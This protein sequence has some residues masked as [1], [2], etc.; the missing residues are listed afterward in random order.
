MDYINSK[1]E[2]SDEFL[3]ET[4]KEVNQNDLDEKIQDNLSSSEPSFYDENSDLPVENIPSV[5][6]KIEFEEVDEKENQT[7]SESVAEKLPSD[8]SEDNQLNQQYREETDK[9][10]KEV[11][12]LRNTKKYVIYVNEENINFIDSLSIEERK[13]IINDIL[14]EQDAYFAA[15]KRQKQRK[16]FLLN[17]L[18]IC[19]TF[20]IGFPIM[21]MVVNKAMQATI[22]NYS[23]SRKNFEK[24]YRNEGKLKKDQPNAKKYYY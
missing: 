16:I 5:K 1:D 10:R 21:F 18:I 23:S 14:H 13:E 15:K 9:I 20:V 24:L 11:E 6:E 19:I 4:D 8:V 22:Q 3:D 12:K 7:N 17:V 2:F